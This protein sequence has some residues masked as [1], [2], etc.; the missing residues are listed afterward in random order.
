VLDELRAER[1]SFGAHA[2]RGPRRYL[3]R[4]PQPLPAG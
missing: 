3:G 1:R 4:R 2:V